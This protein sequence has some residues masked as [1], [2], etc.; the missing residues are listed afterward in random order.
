M[1]DKF[2]IHPGIGH[3]HPHYAGNVAGQTDQTHVKADL[4]KPP[5]P[6]RAFT[7]ALEIHSGMNAKAK[8]GTHF[9]GLSGQDLSRYDADPAGLDTVSAIEGPPRGKRLSPVQPSFGMRSRVNDA[10]ASAEP[11]AAHAAAMLNAADFTKGMTDLSKRVLT[12]AANARGSDVFDRLVLG[13]KLPQST[14]EE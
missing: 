11:G 9:A 3:A 5:L 1:S 12:E 14:T 6:K 2:K 7:E 8:D 10:S 4:G 13:S